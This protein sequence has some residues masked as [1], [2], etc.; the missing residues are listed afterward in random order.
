MR[1]KYD[2]GASLKQYNTILFSNWIPPALLTTLPSFPNCYL[3]TF[4]P[5]WPC[6]LTIPPPFS[7]CHLTPLTHLSLHWNRIQL[8]HL[9]HPPNSPLCH[10]SEPTS[11]P[12]TTSR[13][14]LYTN[15]P[16]PSREGKHVWLIVRQSLMKAGCWK[17]PLALRDLAEG[18]SSFREWSK[19][20]FDSL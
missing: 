2:K 15:V 9:S 14:L 4:R 13:H 20:V 8:T 18:I 11:P 10:I 7:L 5:L 12:S 6:H 16:L 1:K 3:I 17:A 19:Q